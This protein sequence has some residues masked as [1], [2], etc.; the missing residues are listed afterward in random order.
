VKPIADPSVK[1][2]AEALAPG[3]LPGAREKAIM[4]L[5]A[6]PQELKILECY[7]RIALDPKQV[8][9]VRR[10]AVD[11]MEL[12]PN[13]DGARALLRCVGTDLRYPALYSLRKNGLPEAVRKIGPEA[14]AVLV[15]ALRQISSEAEAR[16]NEGLL[17][18]LDLLQQLL[19]LVATPEARSLLP[20]VQA[21]IA[22][23]SNR[24]VP[25]YLERALTSGYHRDVQKALAALESLGTAESKAAQEKFRSVKSRLVEKEVVPGVGCPDENVKLQVY[26]SEF[27][28]PPCEEEVTALAVQADAWGKRHPAPGLLPK[29]QPQPIRP[30]SLPLDNAWPDHAQPDK[31][32]SDN[33]KPVESGSDNTRLEEEAQ[34]Y[35]AASARGL[36]EELLALVNNQLNF[37]KS[38]HLSGSLAPLAAGMDRQGEINGL[39]LTTKDPAADERS[40]ED[41]LNV[42]REKFQDAA[43]QGELVACAIFYHGCHGPGKGALTVAPAQTIADAD[44]IVV[45][46][47]HCDGQ[48]IAGV[49]QY[50]E[51]PDGGWRYAPAYYVPKPPAVFVDSI[52]GPLLPNRAREPIHPRRPAAASDHGTH[53][54]LMTLV[55]SQ[56]EFLK[57]LYRSDSLAPV[58]VAMKPSG[59]IQTSM[60][61]NE[62]VWN[63]QHVETDTRDSVVFYPQS[64]GEKT[65]SGAIAFF[66]E[67]FRIAARN[68]EIVASAIF[69]HGHLRPGDCPAR[70]QTRREGGTQLPR[71]AVGS[72]PE[73]GRFARDPVFVRHP[74][75]VSLRSSR[76]LLRLSTHFQRPLVNR[77]PIAKAACPPKSWRRWMRAFVQTPGRFCHKKA[78]DDTR[79][80]G[81]NRFGVGVRIPKPIRLASLRDSAPP[82]E[83]WIE[84]PR[85][86]SRRA[87]ERRRIACPIIAEKSSSTGNR[88]DRFCTTVLADRSFS[89]GIP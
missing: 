39:A 84:S 33:F 71:R 75:G 65:A 25:Q 61:V 37:L 77:S 13:V 78:Q 35:A 22:Q 6:L 64:D 76:A 34:A 41:A 8:R 49:I 19:G 83:P 52:G 4:A 89:R 66:V 70:A 24:L 42:F 81:R 51:S 87:A 26:T 45:L 63:S 3:V 88:S 50:T 9:K 18:D 85:Q 16:F 20:K 27:G 58:V 7:S 44:C 69:F 5:M 80:T 74:R 38:L 47:D 73:P 12:S 60:V 59:E 79:G 40:V 43:R 11:G 56:L 68:G 28:Q 1:L 55:E 82:R 21:V 36:E 15:E 62:D 14:H 10:K 54:E 72:S 30:A 2:I 48:A 53:P 32:P 86:V 23:M 57:T 31:L 46:L 29:P 67:K 17:T